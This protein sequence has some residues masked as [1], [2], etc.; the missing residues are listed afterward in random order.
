MR[1]KTGGYQRSACA[2]LGGPKL[3]RRPEY[4]GGEHCLPAKRFVGA[5]GMSAVRFTNAPGR[6]CRSMSVPL[7]EIILI[8]SFIRV[9]YTWIQVFQHRDWAIGTITQIGLYQA[10]LVFLMARLQKNNWGKVEK[11]SQFLDLG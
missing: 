8:V 2:W 10:G 11:G 9:A 5:S 7:K 1:R 6:Y 3:L 4:S